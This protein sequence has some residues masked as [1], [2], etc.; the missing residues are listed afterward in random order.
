MRPF[1]RLTCILRSESRALIYD[2]YEDMN[3]WLSADEMDDW[4]EQEEIEYIKYEKN[5]KIQQEQEKYEEECDRI[6]NEIILQ[7]RRVD[8]VKFEIKCRISTDAESRKKRKRDEEINEKRILH[9]H[10]M[11]I[12]YKND[13]IHD[14]QLKVDGNYRILE[15]MHKAKTHT[16]YVNKD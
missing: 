16:C 4:I 13:E 12:K 3:V 7:R 10:Y 1:S 9:A 8:Q 11:E 5:L 14:L 2:Q 15:E 6:D